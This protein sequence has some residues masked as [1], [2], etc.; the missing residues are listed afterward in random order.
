M[1]Q[2][3]YLPSSPDLPALLFCRDNGLELLVHFFSTFRSALPLTLYGLHLLCMSYCHF[4]NCITLRLNSICPTFHLIYI[5]PNP[6]TNYVNIHTASNIHVMRK[7][8]NHTSYLDTQVINIS[9]TTIILFSPANLLTW[10][11]MNT[12]VFELIFG[13]IVLSHL[14]VY[15]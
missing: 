11:H 3:C 6:E 4:S 2:A 9:Q 1:K 8:T 10:T 15:F 13:T 12:L 7:L 5:F 14:A